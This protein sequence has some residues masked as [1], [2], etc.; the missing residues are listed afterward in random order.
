[1]VADTR[2]TETC[3]GRHQ[4]NRDLSVGSDPRGNRDLT[5]GSDPRVAETCGARDLWVQTPGLQ[6][7]VGPDTRVTE[8]CLWVQTPGLQG[9]RDLSVG[10]DPRVTE[11]CGFRPQGQDT[12]FCQQNEW[13]QQETENL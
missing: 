10:S 4:G 7:P 5:V 3:W 8:T 11:T 2:I 6:R 1:M 13:Q 12:C 9:N